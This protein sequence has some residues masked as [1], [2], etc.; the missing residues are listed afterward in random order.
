MQA[1]VVSTTITQKQRRR[2]RLSGCVAL[3]D[4]S[5]MVVRERCFQPQL[6]HPGSSLDNQACI[7]A[8]PK[9]GDLRR[10]RI[11]EI[12]ILAFTKPMLRHVDSTPKAFRTLVQ[13]PD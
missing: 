4:E 7:Q 3:L 5:R 8:L 10:Q 1:V 2:T 12:L 6:I 11:A 13:G 9:L